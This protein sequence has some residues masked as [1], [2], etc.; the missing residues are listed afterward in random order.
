M[1]KAISFIT[2][3]RLSYLDFLII[4][5]LSDIIFPLIWDIIKGL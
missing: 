2:T 4:L 1:K 5:V 3:P